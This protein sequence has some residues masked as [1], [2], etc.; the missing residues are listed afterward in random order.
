MEISC[1]L[2]SLCRV[3]SVKPGDPVVC[4]STV[5]VHSTTYRVKSGGKVLDFGGSLVSSCVLSHPVWLF[6]APVM[7]LIGWFCFF[8]VKDHSISLPA[9]FCAL[10]FLSLCVLPASNTHSV[11]LFLFFAPYLQHSCS[12]SSFLAPPQSCFIFAGL[13]AGSGLWEAKVV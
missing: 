6:A 4:L 1:R 13:D 9:L 5:W 3:C 10:P 11:I 7:V 12:F 2:W 8:P